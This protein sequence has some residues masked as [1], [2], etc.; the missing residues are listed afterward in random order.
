MGHRGFDT[1]QIGD[2]KLDHVGITATRFNFCTQGFQAF[3]AP[4]RQ[5]HRR[6]CLGQGLGEL[7]AQTAGSAGDQGHAAR[8]INVVAHAGSSK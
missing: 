2:V 6:A 1:V 4:P 8:Q 5:H 3:H 7:F